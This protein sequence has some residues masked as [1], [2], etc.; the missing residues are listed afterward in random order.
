MRYATSPV[1]VAAAVR[2]RI[3]TDGAGAACRALLGAGAGSV[4]AASALEVGVPGLPLRPLLALSLGPVPTTGGADQHTASWYIYDDASQGTARIDAIAT[5]LVA[6]YD[7]ERAAPL[8][9]G[10]VDVGALSEPRID[11]A[12]RLRYRRLDLV[13]LT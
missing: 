11:S 5:A 6:L 10:P 2:A 12:L 8:S 4:I 3:A 7:Q 1:A 13:T 9:V